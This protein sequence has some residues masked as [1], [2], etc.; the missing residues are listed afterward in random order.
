MKT[1]QETRIYAANL[2]ADHLDAIGRPYHTHLDRVLAH[3]D[4]L[5]PGAEESVRHGALLH[6]CVEEK[7]ATLEELRAEGYPEETIQMVF[8]NTRPRGEGAPAYLDWIRNLAERAPVEAV[9][10]KIADNEDNNDPQRIALLPEDQRD[11]SA[12]YAQARMI[13]EDGLRRRV[14]PA[15]AKR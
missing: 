11:V 6:S 15:Q 2:H 8:W 12:V 3:L 7:R 5:F 13:L 1:L 14:S 9:M 10:I 4:R